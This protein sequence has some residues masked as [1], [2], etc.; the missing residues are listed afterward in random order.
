MSVGVTETGNRDVAGS[1]QNAIG[2]RQP[3]GIVCFASVDWWY[4]NR[5]HSECQIMI[6]LAKHTRVLWINSMG[7]RMPVP[8]KTEL[9]FRRYARKIKSLLMGLRR[10]PSG[11]WIYTPLFVPRYTKRAQAF[12][13]ALV[14]AQMKLLRW[15]L[16]LKQPATWVTIPSAEPVVQKLEWTRI[17]Y[18]RCDNFSSFPEVD[19]QIVGKLEQA[20]L[21]TADDVVYVNESLYNEEKDQVRQAHYLDHGV[22][23]EHFAGNATFTNGSDRPARIRDLPSPIV[24]F[25]GALDDY[26]IDLN[27]MI[28]VA[29]H[30]HPG[31]LLVIG[32]KAMEIDALIQE[33][34]VVYLGPIPYEELPDYAAHF[35]LGIMPWLQNEWI[36]KCNPIKLKEYLALGFPIVSIR[37]PQIKQYESLVYA[38]DSDDEFLSAVDRGLRGNDPKMVHQRRQ[39]VI[40][41]SWDA[42]AESAGRILGLDSE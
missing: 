6:R 27:L 22:D 39:A 13:A 3:D 35:D 1:V 41:S 38:V 7:L 18:N 26:V 21:Q 8:G 2:K 17:V 14:G 9:P 11:M 37:F 15:W 40:G 20:L 5:G 28:K 19:S 10:D 4:H 30:I 31:T 33:P 16:G 34:N 23:Y 32:P 24:G 25:Y 36:E 29:K 42:L 12:N